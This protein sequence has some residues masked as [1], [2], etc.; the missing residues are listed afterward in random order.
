[1]END[2]KKSLT[3]SQVETVTYALFL[4]GGD[5]R[6]IDTEDV[7]IKAHEL[8]PARF[9]WQKY[10]EQVN[11]ELVRVFLSD[12]KKRANGGLVTG[13]GKGGWS[14]TPSGVRW[15][16]A[17]SQEGQKL[18]INQ[19]ASRTR[20]IDAN[21]RERERARLKGSD[22]WAR[23]AAGED[24]PASAARAAMRIDSYSDQASQRSKLVRLRGL[25]ADDTEMIGFLDALGAVLSIE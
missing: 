13:T 14:L 25:F 23:W 11:L 4:L 8:S 2:N 15:A 17:K 12:A 16:S 19:K 6:S 24:V 3:L 22:G 7:A 10:P 1:M 9:A 21:R 20:S 18:Q 5:Q